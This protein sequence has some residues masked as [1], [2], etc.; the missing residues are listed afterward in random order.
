MP[1]LEQLPALNAALNGTSAILLVIAYILIKNKRIDAHRRVMLTA[2]ATSALFLTSYL[3]YHAQ[4]GSKPYPGVGLMRAVYFSILIPHVLLA[5]LV[6]PLA[7]VTLWRGLA[8]DVARHRKI[9]R[10]TLP[11]WLFV[12]VTG[13]VVYFMLYSG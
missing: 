1:T 11:I 10:I 3:I 5:A 6:L 8:M 7:I 4:I 2:F 9:A 12:S 13:V